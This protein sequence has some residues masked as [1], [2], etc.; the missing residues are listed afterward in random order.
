MEE[1]DVRKEKDSCLWTADKKQFLVSQVSSLLAFKKTKDSMETKWAIV[2]SRLKSNP[3]FE[4]L[5]TDKW[6]TIHQYY[7]RLLKDA[8]Q[9]N[10]LTD[11]TVNLSKLNSSQIDSLDLALIEMKKE[12]IMESKKAQEKKLSKK[13]KSQL[14]AN[15]EQD[16]LHMQAPRDT[17]TSETP[18]RNESGDP[19]S[20]SSSSSSKV[21]SSIASQPLD[22]FQT[23]LAKASKVLDDGVDEEMRAAKLAAF[24]NQAAYYKAMIDNLQK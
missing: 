23:V 9:R 10:G 20:S 13:R 16:A 18:T 3:L 19:T 21:S 24:Q 22:I 14:M 7:E 2:L 15:L 12:S 6:K 11:Q 8:L 1:S 4:D 5:K 17:E